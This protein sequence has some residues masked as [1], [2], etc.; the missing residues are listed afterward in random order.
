MSDTTQTNTIT[1]LGGKGKAK[2]KVTKEERDA[3]VDEI[4]Q[5]HEAIV[6][7]K[8][9]EVSNQG[10]LITFGEGDERRSID[11]KRDI[12]EAKKLFIN[13]IKTLGTLKVGKVPNQNEEGQAKK[14]NGLVESAILLT[15]PMKTF[16]EKADFGFLD[17]EAKAGKK[18]SDLIPNVKKGYMLRLT[19]TYLMCIY[20]KHHGLQH[21]EHKRLIV[22]DTAL[23][24]AVNI[25]P[26]SYNFDK[27]G[28][29]LEDNKTK[30]STMTI[31]R[32]VEKEKHQQLEKNGGKVPELQHFTTADKKTVTIKNPTNLQ[33]IVKFNS[34]SP[35][36]DAEV[37][38][39]VKDNKE[40]L[41]KEF[42][43]IRDTKKK[44]DDGF[45]SSFSK[46]NLV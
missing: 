5:L 23:N 34:I 24:K 31:I 30:E 3:Y 2:K 27:S 7:M 28:E 41:D 13:A 35:K 25:D 1:K 14:K 29:E 21:H 11:P 46:V 45:V 12:P 17:P 19:F 16:V 20:I 38:K 36:D 8:V 40:A 32:K 4:I 43:L 33:S 6:K 39:Y 9:L 42:A 44:Y 37:E 22:P 18:L 26:A 15:G 10:K